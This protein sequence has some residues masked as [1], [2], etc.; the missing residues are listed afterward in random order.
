LRILE[1]IPELFEKGDIEYIHHQAVL[2]NEVVAVEHV[3]AIPRSVDRVDLHALTGRQQDCV[4]ETCTLV[5][6][7]GSVATG[8]A[9]NLEVDQVD[10]RGVDTRSIGVVEFP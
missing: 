2:M 7:Y 9:E 6:E 3:H 5:W 4:F 8:P 1:L 10:M